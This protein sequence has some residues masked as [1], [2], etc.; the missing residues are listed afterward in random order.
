MKVFKKQNSGKMKITIE[1]NTDYIREMLTLYKDI[2]AQVTPLLGAEE[3]SE[4][5]KAIDI[6]ETR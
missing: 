4:V 5:L 3:L 2:A 6:R 1:M